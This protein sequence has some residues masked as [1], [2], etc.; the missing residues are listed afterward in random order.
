MYAVLVRHLFAL[1]FS[2]VFGLYLLPIVISAAQKIGFMDVPD[3]CLKSHKKPTPYLGGVAIFMAFI[4][5]LGL[6]YPFENQIL[7][8]LLGTTLLLF[9]GLVDDLKVLKP[10][11]KFFGQ[12]VA[13]LC[14]LKGE[15]SLKTPLFSSMGSIGWSL[16]WMLTVIN[17]FNLVDVMDG[18][19]ATLALVSAVTLCGIALVLGKFTTSLLLTAFIGATLAFWL[20]NKPPAK[21][22]LG[23]AGS[24]FIGGFLAAIPLL[25]DWDGKLFLWQFDGWLAVIYQMVR[26]LF[27][28]FFVPCLIFGVP[29]LECIS[30]FVIRS[31]L[32]KP[33][34]YGS[35][36][37]FSIYLQKKG[38]SAYQVLGFAVIVSLLL[39]GLAILFL[40]RQISLTGLVLTSFFVIAS[41]IYT[42]FF[43]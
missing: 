12:F 23:D 14:F 24:L 11:Q 42:V 43:S 16:F 22:Y 27:E 20:Y 1:F 31:W 2:F 38:W 40:L 28:V 4:M 7:W 6:C 30:L 13:A 34:Y 19:C 33:F 41:W 17:A 25:F 29:L 9:V 10:Y 21:I 18:L 5:T 37:H 8:F 26:P 15:F 36:H 3:G 35:P 39:S 32:G